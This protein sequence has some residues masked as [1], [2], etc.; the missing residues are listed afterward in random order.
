MKSN[1]LGTIQKTV[2]T[3][4]KRAKRLLESERKYVR[5]SG[6][7]VSVLD[8]GRKAHIC[9]HATTGKNTADVVRCS[10]SGRRR[11]A[12]N[13]RM[14]QYGCRSSMGMVSGNVAFSGSVFNRS[15]ILRCSKCM[16]RSTSVFNP[17]TGITDI[18]IGQLQ[19]ARSQPSE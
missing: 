11:R 17:R 4:M 5:G 1:G 18:K 16:Q 8:Y 10:A 2:L 12:I 7:A 15:R 14:G 13:D 6:A 19:T 9:M 3:Q